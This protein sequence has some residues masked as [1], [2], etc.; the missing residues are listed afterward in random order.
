[1]ALLFLHTQTWCDRIKDSESGRLAPIFICLQTEFVGGINWLAQI[2]LPVR[3]VN[4]G[5]LQLISFG[6]SPVSCFVSFSFFLCFSETVESLVTRKRE[7][8]S[9]CIDGVNTAYQQLKPPSCLCS[10]LKSSRTATWTWRVFELK[11]TFVKS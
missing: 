7:F 1:M 2:K 5:Q 6:F 10:K 8:L 9:R 4:P 11:Q 3:R